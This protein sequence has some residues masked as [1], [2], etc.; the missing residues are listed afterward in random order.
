MPKQREAYYDNAKLFLILCIMAGHLL[1]DFRMDSRVLHAAYNFIYTF[2]I[3][4]F[5]F[6]SGYFS[7]PRKGREFVLSQARRFLLP[8]LAM[9]LV[10]HVFY[11]FV[12]GNPLLPLRIYHPHWTLWYLV[13]LFAWRVLLYPVTRLPQP[14][15]WAIGGGLAI[16]LIDPAGC[17]LSICRTF[18]FFPLFVAGYLTAE[19]E[20]RW[21]ARPGARIGAVAALVPVAVA[22]YAIKPLALEDWLLGC[23]SYHYMEVSRLLGVVIRFGVYSLSAAAT[24]GVLALVPTRRLLFTSLGSRTLYIFLLHGFLAQLLLISEPFKEAISAGHYWLLVGAP[25]LFAIVLAS[26]P[27][28]E[29]FK[30][31]VEMKKPD[32]KALRKGFSLK[33]SPNPHRHRSGTLSERHR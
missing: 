18:V 4:A 3:P 26:P 30:P 14:L 29:L 15:L 33:D 24:A 21:L 31:I 6:I 8:F 16:G 19:H 27:V 10:Y 28:V 22:S 17:E 2:H 20:P 12:S 7:K 5:V 1:N 32:W 11:H 23:Y 25:L 13:S 9:H